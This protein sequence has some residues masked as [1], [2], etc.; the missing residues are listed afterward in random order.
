MTNSSNAKS[1]TVDTKN[2]TRSDHQYHYSN[3]MYRHECTNKTISACART[4]A[5]TNSRMHASAQARTHALT[6]FQHARNPSTHA[7]TKHAR[8]HALPARAHYSMRA[9]THKHMH[10][11]SCTHARTHARSHVYAHAQRHART[12]PPTCSHIDAGTTRKQRPTGLSLKD[13]WKGARLAPMY[14]HL[15]ACVLTARLYSSSLQ[16]AS[17][18]RLYS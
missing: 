5:R 1:S 16:L 11:D 17:T 7:R 3:Q 13:K 8:T 4:H 14:V 18:A 12:H 9:C 15:C 2:L 6:G 10:M